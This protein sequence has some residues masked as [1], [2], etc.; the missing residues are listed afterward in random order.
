MWLLS[1]I[2]AYTFIY[3]KLQFNHKI[4]LRLTPKYISSIDCIHNFKSSSWVIIQ[5]ALGSSHKLYINSKFNIVYKR[6]FIIVHQR[7]NIE[8]FNYDA[9]IHLIS[10]WCISF[11]LMLIRSKYRY[12]GFKIKL[13]LPMLERALV[14]VMYAF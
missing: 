1:L 11:W 10:S 7:K 9:M 3:Y 2:V 5:D 12:M 13:L 14:A 6:N 4:F 8:I